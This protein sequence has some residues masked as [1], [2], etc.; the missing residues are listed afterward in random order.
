MNAETVERLL[1]IEGDLDVKAA[2]AESQAERA[3]YEEQALQAHRIRRVAED[4]ERLA[5]AKTR[6]QKDLVAAKDNGA[7][8]RELA[9]AS[10]LSIETVRT[11]LGDSFAGGGSRSEADELVDRLVREGDDP[12][13]LIVR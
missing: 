8:L 10:G 11:R 1:R 6:L 13:G 2:T 5:D 12:E 4:A 7:T 3:M 9:D